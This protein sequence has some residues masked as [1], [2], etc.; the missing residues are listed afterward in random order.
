M[1]APSLLLLP[2]AV[3]FVLF[4]DELVDFGKAR[5]FDELIEFGLST[6]AHDPGDAAAV[7]GQGAGD[8]FQLGVPGLAGVQEIAAGFD[9]RG[10]AGPQSRL[11][12]LRFGR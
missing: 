8:H 5:G 9:G 10:D 1:T 7:A 3:A 6:P 2:G 12:P 4:T 11:R